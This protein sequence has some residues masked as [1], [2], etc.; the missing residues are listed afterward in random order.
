MK[1]FVLFLMVTMVWTLSAQSVQR[2]FS[3]NRSE[4]RPKHLTQEEVDRIARQAVENTLVQN[5]EVFSPLAGSFKKSYQIG[6][7]REFFAINM[8]TN[9]YYRLTATLKAQGTMSRIWVENASLD[10]NYVTDQIV[11]AIL[12][13]L[14]HHTAEGSI[15]PNKGILEIDTEYFG[16]PPNYDGDGIV[17]FLMLDI[18]DGWQPGQGFIAGYFTSHDQTTGYGSNKMDMLYLDT[19]PGVYY[20]G[21]Y[22]TATVMGTTSHE[23]QHLIHFNYDPAELTFFNEAMSQ[24]AATYCGYGVDDPMRYLSQPNSNLIVW[25]ST[26]YD[27]A[28]ANV[29]SL[30]LAEQFGPDF[31]RAFVQSSMQGIG[32]IN[33]VLASF[34]YQERF[35]DVYQNF[36]VANIV[37]D[38]SV[39]KR[40]GY[41]HPDMQGVKAYNENIVNFP[42]TKTATLSQYGALYYTIRGGKNAVIRPQGTGAF[43]KLVRMGNPVEVVDLQL[44]SDNAE[45]GFGNDYSMAYVVFGTTGSDENVSLNVQAEQNALFAELKY[46]DGTPDQ[47]GDGYTYLGTGDST[48][49]YG[50][51]VE[52][53]MP[54]NTFNLLQSMK[55][56]V[57]GGGEVQ[58]RILSWNNG[59]P[60]E[61]LVDPIDAVFNTGWNE[62]DLTSYNITLPQKFFI[63][64]THKN[65]QAAV[66]VGMDNSTTTNHTW[67][68]RPNGNHQELSSLGNGDYAGYNMMIRATVLVQN[69]QKARFASGILQNP[70]FR[71]NGDLFIVANSALDLN[72]TRAWLITGSGETE[73]QLSSA[74]LLRRILVSKGMVFE[75]SGQYSVRIIGR[76]VGAVVETDTTIQF[77]VNLMKVGEDNLISLDG[78]RARLVVRPNSLRD[79]NVLLSQRGAVVSSYEQWMRV[80][81]LLKDA[82][83]V[84]TLQFDA[85]TLRE[86]MQLEWESLSGQER[87]AYVE[88]GEMIFIPVLRQNGKIVAQ[89]SKP[90]IYARIAGSGEEAPVVSQFTLYQNYPNPFN[91]IT[92][93]ELALP[94]TGPL[95]LTVYNIVGQ[96]VKT[97]YN[98]IAQKGTYRFVWDGRDE[99]G[100]AV[101]SGVYIYRAEYQGRSESRK[102][103]LMK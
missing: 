38:T 67:I 77:S 52:Y 7:Q 86:P 14:E 63:G 45:P 8:T 15:D 69:D 61:D 51:V 94:E 103:I 49:G 70:L 75:N 39:D 80:N 56:L 91:P 18:K 12:D 21:R 13:N 36:L 92:Q 58:I 3:D 79:D 16:E 50:W 28:R 25:N 22:T 10:S 6:E 82:S 95:T 96:K 32:A 81:E 87:L 11:A 33:A 41:S 54:E 65:D 83:E 34:G 78:G 57:S 90:G 99:S 76:Y 35:P 55:I 43:A 31:I 66:Y 85:K 42:E 4:I 20:N 100:N 5:P 40:Y 46:D 101:S 30:Y 59:A 93:I 97:L 62:K 37:N 17:D 60:G 19:Y 72:A 53:E 71:K 68:F 1:K 2:L 98:G 23:F 102:M 44:N 47:F 74:D 48:A 27:Y 29:F 89:I 84:F 64:F 88:N 24:L 9:T 26:L 73:L